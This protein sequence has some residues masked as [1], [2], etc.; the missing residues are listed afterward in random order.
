MADFQNTPRPRLPQRLPDYY[1]KTPSSILRTLSR[2]STLPPD[3][4]NNTPAS[5]ARKLRPEM[6]SN[7]VTHLPVREE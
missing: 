1:V 6:P 5:D 4:E 3:K 7:I 2:I